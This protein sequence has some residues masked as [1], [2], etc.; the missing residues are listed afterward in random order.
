M[1]NPI[2][3]VHLLQ[4]CV[5]IFTFQRTRLSETFKS[6]F[7]IL[8]FSE[9]LKMMRHIGF[10]AATL[11]MVTGAPPGVNTALTPFALAIT[12]A[13]LAE[14]G[15]KSHKKHH[16]KK[17]SNKCPSGQQGVA[18]PPGPKG[19]KGDQ[20][21]AGCPFCGDGDC[22]HDQFEDPKCNCTGTGFSGT[23]CETNID[24]CAG[25][26]CNTGSC[27]D[28]VND[29]TCDCSGTGFEGDN[30]QDCGARFPGSIVGAQWPSIQAGCFF[31]KSL[32]VPESAD[33]CA[34]ACTAE[35]AAC[36]WWSYGPTF[37]CRIGGGCL[38]SVYQTDF[39]LVAGSE[40]DGQSFSRFYSPGCIGIT[41]GCVYDG[42]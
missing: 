13:T 18:G 40:D 8:L 22:Y 7:L 34:D 41:R 21:L 33:G 5:C 15:K 29:Y 36:D 37:G 9:S 17:H 30:C 11:G 31:W 20:G 26:P 14:A 19:A 39:C 16:K 10:G 32:R 3:T 12:S 1:A 38:D 35:S 42:P 2:T 25:D 27:Q 4:V 28:L 6:D 23:N 24:D